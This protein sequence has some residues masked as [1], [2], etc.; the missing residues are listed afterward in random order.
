MDKKTTIKAD[1]KSG[2]FPNFEKGK[3]KPKGM[4]GKAMMKKGMARGR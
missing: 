4:K 1:K 3:M 2:K